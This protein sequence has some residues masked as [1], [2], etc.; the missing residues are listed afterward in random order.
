[1]TS[2]SIDSSDAGAIQWPNN[3]A[4]ASHGSILESLKRSV[5]NIAAATFSGIGNWSFYGAAY[6]FGGPYSRA[7]GSVLGVSEFLSYFTFRL[8]NFDQIREEFSNDPSAKIE[9]FLPTPELSSVRSNPLAPS[10]SSVSA[11][12]RGTN[13]NDSATEPSTCNWNDTA[14]KIALAGL[15]IAAQFPIM[16]LVYY[17]NNGNLVYPL[18]TGVCEGSFTVLS[19]W[20]SL[21]SSKKLAT[22]SES[23]STF[24]DTRQSLLEQVDRLKEEL[25]LKYN[26][27]V[28]EEQI[29]SIF[30]PKKTNGDR[31]R[32]L[33]GLILA[34]E[35]YPE[36][37]KG[38]FD[39]ALQKLATGLGL[40]TAAYLTTVNGMVTYKGV[41]A[42]NPEQKAL[43]GVAT[44]VVC[45]ANAEFLGRLC[46]NSAKD[47][48][49]GIRDVAKGQYRAPLAGV[50]S[51]YKWLAGRVLSTTSSW[52]SWGTTALGARDYFPAPE[53]KV[54]I[55][56][57]PLSSA[58]LLNGALNETA[59]DVVLWACSSDQKVKRFAHIQKCLLTFRA[60]LETAEV[61]PLENYLQPLGYIDKPRPRLRP[62]SCLDTPLL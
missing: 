20:M 1:M 4:S 6:S 40:F 25:A 15:G 36:L 49:E 23:D 18:I 61:K 7:F 42:W 44:A 14:Q 46:I 5:F 54:F 27:P 41:L 21:R 12:E 39:H 9:I 8:K 37:D 3:S 10:D 48:Y 26:D 22:N 32:E 57:A 59:D 24:E 56:P 11:L 51:P 62:S 58:L 60:R 28:F 45:I 17:G 16:V 29:N 19:L 2:S 43:A 33:L 50:V 38:R 47:Y 13:E 34:A 30:S 55:G 52:L 53:N 35:G 31:E